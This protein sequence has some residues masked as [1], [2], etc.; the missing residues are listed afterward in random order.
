[1]SGRWKLWGDWLLGGAVDKIGICFNAEKYFSGGWGDNVKEGFVTLPPC[2]PAVA[3]GEWRCP[4]CHGANHCVQ[5][6]S[7][8]G[9]FRT[10]D[11]SGLHE[12]VQIAHVE[13]W[14]PVVSKGLQIQTT[15]K[16][17]G[18]LQLSV[19]LPECTP[20]VVCLPHTGDEWYE[21]REQIYA[22]RLCPRG[23]CIC[24]L[25]G[26]FYG[27]RRPPHQPTHKFVTVSD[28][29]LLGR[30]N[31]ED[32]RSLLAW[33][34]NQG[35]AKL[36]VA[37]ISMGASMGAVAVQ[38]FPGKVALAAGLIG[39]S[40]ADAYVHG[41]MAHA[42]DWQALQQPGQD[43]KQALHAIME[44]CSNLTQLPPPQAPEAVVLVGALS[45]QYVPPASV[46]KVAQH[47]QCSP[48]QVHWVPG[49]HIVAIT[50]AGDAFADAVSVALR[51]LPD[52]MN[53]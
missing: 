39:C 25:M 10:R 15:C 46:R 44:R 5:R 38:L 2:V 37:G 12:T 26:A 52:K 8:R 17:H 1:M 16:Q 20:F 33:A 4:M 30:T 36:C 42:V 14:M 3:W 7:R 48:Q 6:V 29:A 19:P 43:T 35:F 27:L 47:F 32:T 40:A 21:A 18:R 34:Q 24:L 50:A 13:Q 41:C 31:V 49:G 45:D 28:F 9:T 53:F 11:C 22:H 23:M 51:A